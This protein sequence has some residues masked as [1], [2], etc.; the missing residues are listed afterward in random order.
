MKRLSLLTLIALSN[1]AY[2]QSTL[3]LQK[4]A[5][6]PI[7]YYISLPKDWTKAKS[8][9]VVVVL[10]AADK[11]YQKNAERFVTARGD[12]PFI[13]VAPFNTNNGNQ[14]R[15]DPK[16]FPYSNETWDYMEKVG[17]CQFN[18]EG[19]EKI[20]QEVADKYNGEKKV[21][22]TG[23]EA[24]AHVLWS[25]VLN[26]PELLK[27]AAPVAGNFRNR[28]VESGKTSN[29]PSKKNLPIKSFVGDGDEYFRPSGKVYNQWTEVK[30]LA[31]SNGYENI[32][33]NVIAK[34][35]HEPM[36]SEVMNYFL[37]LLKK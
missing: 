13:L 20:I 11:E 14:G 30:S 37:S 29:D 25:I 27:A 35:G 21:Y 36:P 12:M 28:C 18:D 1:V 19:I 7:Q 32:S 31:E 3:T 26:H 9:P 6:H 17:D 34:K 4:A 8:W 5:G 24:G 22:I 15:R 16:L 2:S 23:F 33:E 10:E